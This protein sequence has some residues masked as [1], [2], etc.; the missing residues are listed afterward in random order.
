MER[1]IKLQM[2]GEYTLSEIRQAIVNGLSYEYLV[3]KMSSLIGEHKD[4]DLSDICNGIDM[5]LSNSNTLAY[6]GV[7]EWSNVKEF[8]YNTLIMIAGQLDTALLNYKKIERGGDLLK[9]LQEDLENF[10][11]G[12]AQVSIVDGL[13]TYDTEIVKE[14]YVNRVVEQISSIDMMNTMFENFK[15]LP[16]LEPMDTAK[17][18]NKVVEDKLAKLGSRIE[19]IK[20]RL[21]KNYEGLQDTLV[22]SYG[23]FYQL[24]SQTMLDGEK[25]EKARAIIKTF[26]VH[27]KTLDKIQDRLTESNELSRQLILSKNKL[28]ASTEE[29]I[30]EF[31]EQ[32]AGISSGQDIVENERDT[33]RYV[34]DTYVKKIEYCFGAVKNLNEEIARQFDL[35]DK[36]ETTLKSA[37]P[38][39]N[40]LKRY[41]LIVDKYKELIVK[42]KMKKEQLVI[43]DKD[44][45]LAIETAVDGMT[46]MI[47]VINDGKDLV[48]RNSLM[49]AVFNTV[50]ILYDLVDDDNRFKEFTSIQYVSENA[51]KYSEMNMEFA[52]YTVDF[53]KLAND[54]IRNI[55][56]TL[57][58]SFTGENIML[59]LKMLNELLEKIQTIYGVLDEN[60]KNQAQ[61]IENI[62]GV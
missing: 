32:I 34:T 45:F 60:N 59:I 4:V 43:K 22:N 58:K 1:K 35:L 48:I 11:I 41:S 26:S 25:E 19:E 39:S 53:R 9:G 16:R 5:L 6:K 42:L 2:A 55:S 47:Q 62:I 15:T 31:D 51:T 46:A 44:V 56:I 18:A 7:R 13:V 21:N 29:K 27:R 30:K 49:S 54:G 10:I 28:I 38:T 33:L 23:K 37:I 57:G 8:L 12:L 20:D 40:E 50:N 61:F 36:I 24:H 17:F 14:E 3:E 52:K